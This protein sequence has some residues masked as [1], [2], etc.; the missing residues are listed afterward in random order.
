MGTTYE[1]FGAESSIKERITSTI[2][3]I[4]WYKDYITDDDIVYPNDADKEAFIMRNKDILTNIHCL[5]NEILKL[6][7][8]VEKNEYTLTQK[9]IEM[10]G[11]MAAVIMR[12]IG[13]L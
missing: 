8:C 12:Y 10:K 11:I 3:M 9:E 6:Q 1:E 4:L 5:K 13:M 2:E 7:D